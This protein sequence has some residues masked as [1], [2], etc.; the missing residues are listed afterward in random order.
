[1]SSAVDAEQV[2]PA[3]ALPAKV[4]ASAWRRWLA[5]L[6]WYVR[7]AL[8]T[9]SNFLIFVVVAFLLVRL[10]PGDPVVAATQ[11]RVQGEALEA[12]RE[13][14]GLTGSLWDQFLS[15]LGQLV[16]LDLGTSIA[17]GRPVVDDLV[18]RLPATLE[19][20]A[21]G[22]GA[23]MVTALLLSHFC[24][25][26]RASRM[27]KLLTS[28][29][30]SA[31]AFPEYVIAIFLLFFFYAVLAWVPA[32]SGRLGA[33]LTPPPGVTNFP[34]LDAVL[35]GDM[36]ALSSYAAHLV[37]PVITMVLAHTAVLM[38]TLISSLD[39]AIDAPSTRFRI[40]SGASS[41][42]VLLS[43]YRRAL[44]AAV[45][46]LGMLFGAFLGG[47][48]VLEALFGLGGLGQYAVDAVQASD[49]FALRSF[50]LVT[51]G[52]CLIIYFFIDVVTALIDPRRQ[53]IKEGGGL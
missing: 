39:D 36:R 41:V 47:A 24:V 27:S 34:M 12:A 42:T 19:L 51:A 38:Q 45:A 17:T 46:M 4:R 25:M 28:Y 23:S 52:V 7:S 49:I 3:E 22:L 30:R 8:V 5:W 16:T 50:L 35:A 13:R 40:A 53:S 10:V 6:P 48:V 43:I 14:L 44:P 26:H 37:L 18:T 31:G 15:Y 32:P 2:M 9:I 1:M 11:G 29:A 20:V 21:C 33:L